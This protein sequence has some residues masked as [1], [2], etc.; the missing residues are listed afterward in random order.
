[1]K[2]S[3]A[4]ATYNGARY[5]EEQLDSFLKQTRL[6]DEVVVSDDGSTDE[7]LAIVDS[8]AKKA[9]FEV[10]ILRNDRNLGCCKNFELALSGSSG[11]IVLLSDQDDVWFPHKIETIERTFL[12]N[13][14]LL[15]VINDAEITEENLQ[16]TG[17]SNLAQIKAL[18]LG[19]DDFIT[20]C[21][22]AV[23]R[24]MIRLACPIP[25]ISV[26]HDA[27]IHDLGNLLGVRKVVSPV[28]QY[29]RRH[30]NT[31]SNW[32]ASS[33]SK[34]G[35]V[36]LIKSYMRQDPRPW[37]ERTLV[38]LSLLENRLSAHCQPI[39]DLPEL[40]DAVTSALQKVEEERQATQRRLR[41]LRLR[42]LERLGPACRMFIRGD[43]K[44]FSG[45][46]SFAKDILVDAS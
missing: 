35:R 28:L 42:P 38:R 34:V 19:L 37:C 39:V 1:M 32:L 14:G 29:Y 43:Y 30:Q 33:T 44:Y 31:T 10:R 26:M 41:M 5:L 24:K 8:F 9:L 25:H 40:T 13:S 17:L 20:G 16:S 4:M 45:W 12:E 22:T 18:G 3:I 11:D 36:D 15:V 21:C 6:P 2:I 23:T 46:K 7:T 27:W